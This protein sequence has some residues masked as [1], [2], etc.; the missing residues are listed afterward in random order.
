MPET[1]YTPFTY[2]IRL[3][4]SNIDRLKEYSAMQKGIPRTEEVKNKIK[5][6]KKERRNG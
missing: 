5:A 2:L 1:T 4:S 3:V 6:T